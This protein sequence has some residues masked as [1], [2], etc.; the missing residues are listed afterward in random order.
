V[1]QQ[2]PQPPPQ[3]P[4]QQGSQQAPAQFQAPYSSPNQA[5]PQQQ[6]GPPPGYNPQPPRKRGKTLLLVGLLVVA[7]IA[8]IGV[9]SWKLLGSDDQAAAGTAPGRSST[10]D[11]DHGTSVQPGK[12]LQ[13][14]KTSKPSKTIKPGEPVTAQSLSDVDPTAFWESVAT[15]QMV[16]PIGRVVASDFDTVQKFTAHD[17]HTV[18]DIAIDHRTGKFYYYQT[19]NGGKW[20]SRTVC[21]AGKVMAR[22]FDRPWF[23]SSLTSEGLCTK[24]PLYGGHDSIVSSG[25]TAAQAAQVLTTFRNH[26]GFVNPAKPT[27]LSTGGK[28]YVRQVVD[29]KPVDLAGNYY[30]ASLAQIALQDAG[31]SPATWPWNS[32]FG[33]E[34]GIHFVYYLDVATLLPV[35]AFE[36]AIAPPSGSGDAVSGSQ[37]VEVV[38]YTFPK[39]LPV[40]RLD[41]SRTYLPLTLPEGW[42]VQ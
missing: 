34:E 26:A 24:K 35:A 3:P 5:G 41:N 18:E 8:G 36:K 38:N 39:T 31:I 19:A 13:P 14:G 15:R 21:V 29:F 4:Y 16:Q 40:G 25:L 1:T 6:F 33:L 17:I 20:V 37:K 7:V 27:L 9:I 23:Q 10:S 11:G 28:T 22:A 12:T 32:T 30:G 42:K 2:A